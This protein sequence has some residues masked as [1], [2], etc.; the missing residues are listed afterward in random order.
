MWQAG[1]GDARGR[2]AGGRVG[3]YL[4][5]MGGRYLPLPTKPE[6]QGRRFR[7]C[8]RL[9]SSE[10]GTR[11]SRAGRESKLRPE[12]RE[13]R[14]GSWTGTARDACARTVTPSE[15]PKRAFR[16]A[17]RERCTMT[18]ADYVRAEQVRGCQALLPIDQGSAVKENPR[19]TADIGRSTRTARMHERRRPAGRANHA[20]WGARI[21]SRGVADHG[22]RM[23]PSEG[24]SK[25]IETSN[26]TPGVR[27]A[28][29][30]RLC[31]GRASAG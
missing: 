21:A 1:T 23:H 2:R 12:K 25:K 24:E 31:Y 16:S 15:P 4:R 8:E 13:D 14:E 29:G 9:A 10:G 20:C 5:G 18:Q 26:Y 28:L 6:A 7:A 30:G 17:K 22:R 3:A 19:E 11:A 27:C